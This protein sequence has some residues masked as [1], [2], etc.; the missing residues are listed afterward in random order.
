ML[1]ISDELAKKPQELSDYL[2]FIN[3][4]NRHEP[5]TVVNS[6]HLGRA[7][8]TKGPSPVMACRYASRFHPERAIMRATRGPRPGRKSALGCD[9]FKGRGIMS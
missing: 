5:F 1:S 4:A 6:C 8:P 9:D 3:F 7:Q 2:S